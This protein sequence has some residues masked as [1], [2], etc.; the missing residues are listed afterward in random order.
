[1]SKATWIISAFMSN[2]IPPLECC[3]HCHVQCT[4]YHHHSLTVL[5]WIVLFSLHLKA[6]V[7]LSHCRQS[8][9]LNC[10]R[11]LK[12]HAV[13]SHH[14][15]AHLTY[16]MCTRKILQ[17]TQSFV[18]NRVSTKSKLHCL[19]RTRPQQ[20]PYCLNKQLFSA[21]LESVRLLLNKTFQVVSTSSI[22]L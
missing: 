3:H 9:I 1:M 21:L 22:S 10:W 14:T 19:H 6:W 11:S 5:V 12:L 15:L 17:F 7:L 2:I 4:I 18:H 13:C 20:D 16:T 8:W